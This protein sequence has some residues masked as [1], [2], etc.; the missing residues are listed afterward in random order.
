MLK[1]DAIIKKM[2]LEEKISQIIIG[3][4]LM[5]KGTSLLNIKPVKFCDA[6]KIYSLDCD[7]SD[8]GKTWNKKLIQALGATIGNKASEEGINTIFGINIS[9]LKLNNS[10]QNKKSI[11]SNHFLI[12]NLISSY[13]KGIQSQNV[14][15]CVNAVTIDGLKSLKKIIANSLELQTLRNVIIDSKPRYL[16]FETNNIYGIEEGEL[17]TK[18]NSIIKSDYGYEGLIINKTSSSQDMIAG[19]HLGYSLIMTDNKEEAIEKIK[20]A[21]EKFK[22]CHAKVAN[23]EM[24]YDESRKLQN[25]GITLSEYDLDTCVD[26]VIDFLLSSR[27]K[28]NI[29]GLEGNIER[30]IAEESIILLKNDNTLPINKNSN[31][32]VINQ[33]SDDLALTPSTNEFEINYLQNKLINVLEYISHEVTDDTIAS[34]KGKEKLDYVIVYLRPSKGDIKN[35]QFVLPDFQISLLKKLKEGAKYKIIG[36]L[37]TDALVTI[38]WDNYCD[39]LIYSS[40]NNNYAIE[41]ILDIIDGFISPSG[42]LNFDV[43]YVIDPSNYENENLSEGT[44]LK[45]ALGHGLT[46]AEFKYDYFEVT[47]NKISFTIINKS[48]KPGKVTYQIYMSSPSSSIIDLV[49]FDKIELAPYES[50]NITISLNQEIYRNPKKSLMEIVNG[51]YKF[52]L[53]ESGS[54]MIDLKEINIDN[55]NLERKKETKT[56]ELPKKN[57]KK[58]DK[59]KFTIWLILTL[60]FN[61]IFGYLIYKM[62]I[63]IDV[64]GLFCILVITI[65]TDII[66]IVC[67]RTIYKSQKIVVKADSKEKLLEE[68]TFGEEEESERLKIEEVEEIEKEEEE[69]EI[70]EEEEASEIQEEITIIDNELEI[71]DVVK[72]FTDF[73]KNFGLDIKKV[74]SNQFFSALTGSQL[75]FLRNK[76]SKLCER[77]IILF[78]KYVNSKVYIQEIAE[79]WEENENAMEKELND[80]SPFLKGITSATKERNALNIVTLKNVNPQKMNAYFNKF[81]KGLTEV[82]N[83][84][85]IIKFGNHKLHIPTNLWFVAIVNDDNA[86]PLE[87]ASVSTT[88]DLK[89]SETEVD[90]DLLEIKET[91]LFTY[92]NFKNCVELDRN[93]KYIKEIWWQKLDGI[94]SYVDKLSPFEIN[95]RLQCQLENMIAFLIGCQEEEPDALDNAMTIK[96]MPIFEQILKLDKVEERNNFYDELSNKFG[97][98]A[99]VLCSEYLNNLKK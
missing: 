74:S 82:F 86:M 71:F 6:R 25:E 84:D 56:S 60:Y 4:D 22:E 66:S 45:Y 59:V 99:I 83:N 97:S 54:N 11:A 39:A 30:K 69:E 37:Q 23:Q 75:I 2:T 38:D 92:A 50:K 21:L 65:I 42:K 61:I 27:E 94:I 9:P 96:L 7:F 3:N 80:L 46:Y 78:S 79:N 44:S 40:L 12:S 53:A 49:C 58:I 47:R 20:I 31:V 28:E 55:Q 15:T 64:A 52:Y 34:L 77:F 88:I 26:K 89:A 48:N 36:V 87:L 13:I 90:N 57:K 10:E 24:S 81:T 18:I 70:E 98:D 51:N 72:D 73:A 33:K 14:D 76:D 19:L 35:N 62:V 16:C 85:I 68:L 91:A 17:L 8:L 67:I 95:N 5:I 29:K 41:V 93:D 1:R 63:D 43:P 32:I